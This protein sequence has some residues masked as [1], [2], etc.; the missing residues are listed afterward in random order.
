MSFFHSD[1]SSIIHISFRR[2]SA[3]FDAPG[4]AQ[5]CD[6]S[7]LASC[8]PVQS[9]DC[10]YLTVTAPIS[11]GT[12]SNNGTH[13]VMVW[14]HGGLFTTGYGSSPLFNSTA[15]AQK[16]VIVVTLNYRLGSL[17]FMASSVYGF[18]G[19]YGFQD[20]RL[21]MEWVQTNIGGFGG[22]VHRVT[23]A[24]QEAGA[25]AVGAHI[26]SKNSRDY[27]NFKAAIMESNPFG[28]TLQT[29][30]TASGFA[31]DVVTKVGCGQGSDAIGCM[32]G[33]STAEI[34]Y[35]EQTGLPQYAAGLFFFTPLVDPTVDGDIID[36]PFHLFAHGNFIPLPLLAGTVQDGGLVLAYTLLGE[37]L[38]GLDTTA[39]DLTF[40]ISVSN[41]FGAQNVDLLEETYPA[42]TTAASY[43]Y[44]KVQ[45]MGEMLTDYGYFCALRNGSLGNQ[46]PNSQYRI[47]KYNVSKPFLYRYEHYP[48]FLPQ[49]AYCAPDRVCVGAE[50]P[51]VFQTL[52]DPTLASKYISQPQAA[53]YTLS[54]S[55]SDAWVNF[56]V[57]GNPTVGRTL[58]AGFTF[59]A[60][61]LA[62][63]SIQIIGSE[64]GY[65]STA[66][67]FTRSSYCALWD[68]LNE[69]PASVVTAPFVSYSPTRK[70]SASPVNSGD[71]GVDS[72]LAA[73][74]AVPI[75]LVFVAFVI[76]GV[77][78]M[79]G[80]WKCD[81]AIW[82]RLHGNGR[83]GRMPLKQ[84]VIEAEDGHAILDE[85]SDGVSLTVSR[86]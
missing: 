30:S 18:T 42:P 33:K 78:R 41:E 60:F 16:G 52:S 67:S 72:S 84:F 35:A 17:G 40:D 27:G 59:P 10:L 20:Q 5:N 7:T 70:P 19:N 39:A 34:L 69:Y 80:R 77:V 43:S 71:F 75:I 12:V 54:E 3:D 38:S 65:V 31:N 36:Q 11:N 23:L 46:L 13:A 68:S 79:T 74:V 61:D 8:P 6:S 53:D 57:S 63:E 50:L 49:P 15:F 1:K 62:T 83:D 51:Y 24:G 29:Y 56:I 4:C 25:M 2:Y 85:Q 44:D 32:R 21:A 14:L 66:S 48:S 86:R 73:A 45:Q 81:E 76:W 47:D 82:A 55:M 64:G 9:E 58:G 26:V 28:I 22:D 37:S